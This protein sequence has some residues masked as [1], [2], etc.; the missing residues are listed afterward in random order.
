MVSAGPSIIIQIDVDASAFD[1]FIDRMEKDIDESLDRLAEEIEWAWRIKAS[2]QLNTSKKE[3]L[4][5]L[6]IERVD[7]TIQAVL[8]GFIP[9]AVE[10]GYGQY[11]MKPG[12]LGNALYK[13]IPIGKKAGKTPTFRT[14]TKNSKGWIHPG[15]KK[16]AIGEQIQDDMDEI[17]KKAFAPMFRKSV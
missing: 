8:K 1:K 7:D 11:D 6:H 12:M 9:N 14:M 3:Y 5:G 15:F 16:R 13:V 4:D 17:A 2:Q 10:E